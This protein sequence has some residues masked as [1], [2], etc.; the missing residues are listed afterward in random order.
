MTYDPDKQPPAYVPGPNAQSEECLELQKKWGPMIE[1]SVEENQIAE[2]RDDSEYMQ[3]VRTPM[4]QAQKEI[5]MNDQATKY[6]IAKAAR[7]NRQN[8]EEIVLREK[9]RAAG[10]KVANTQGSR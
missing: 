7:E 10:C 2:D 6:E 5:V 3:L 9:Q 1:R 8:N 4:P